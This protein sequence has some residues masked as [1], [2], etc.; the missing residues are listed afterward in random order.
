MSESELWDIEAKWSQDPTCPKDLKVISPFTDETRPNLILQQYC[1]LEY[2]I[3]LRVKCCPEAKY[4]GTCMVVPE[5]LWLR[6]A[7]TESLTF[8][9]AW[10]A[11]KGN[12]HGTGQCGPIV[13]YAE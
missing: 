11:C 6:S 10:M 3:L 8:D 1:S 7:F 12:I 5:V 9:G 2:L 13:L 4:S